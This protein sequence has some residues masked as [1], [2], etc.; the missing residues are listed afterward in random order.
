MQR[1]V[2]VLSL[3]VVGMVMGCG[4][5]STTNTSGTPTQTGPYAGFVQSYTVP[6]VGTPNFA[7]LTSLLQVQARVNGGTIENFTIDTGSVG[8][9]VPASEVPNIPANS[10]SG[11]ITYSSSG[12][13]MNGVWATLPMTFPQAVNGY[14]GTEVATATVPV[15]A[16]TSTVCTGVGPNAGNCTG[17]IPHQLGVGFGRGTT[18]QLSPVYNPFLNLAEMTA[19]TMRR[20]YI[21]Q[22]AGLVL[23]LTATNVGSSFVT[24]TLTSAGTPAAGT[25]NDWVTP[26]GGFTV[27]STVMASGVALVDTGL[28]DMILEASGEPSSGAVS[29]GTAMTITLGTQSYSY[30]LGDGGAQTPTSA[31]WAIYSTRAFVNTGLR[32]LGHFD[33]MFDADNGLF[34]LRPE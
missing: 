1:M 22:R 15:L 16:V 13:Q 21:L 29:S 10:P 26:A 6:Y 11:S 9:V 24:Q 19:G 27:G 28:T 23:G 4:S 33:L 5:S 2:L 12:L 20:G 3:P 30:K 8:V 14:G 7:N 32:A 17:A 34:G 31:N 25:K 18:V